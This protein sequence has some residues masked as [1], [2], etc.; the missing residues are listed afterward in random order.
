VKAM[1]ERYVK[2]A[3]LDLGGGPASDNSRAKAAVTASTE[4]PRLL[5]PAWNAPVL[6]NGRLYLRGRDQI[7][8]LRVG[9]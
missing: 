5:F 8:C 7:V 6:S 9:K 2:V 4:R 3:E 1:P